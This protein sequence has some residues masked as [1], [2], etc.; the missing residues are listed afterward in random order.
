MSLNSYQPGDLIINDM[1]LAGKKVSTGFISG[2]IYESIFMPCVVGEFN[3][4]DNDDALFGG[5]NLSGGEPLNIT[6]QTP[7]GNKITY[8]FLIHKPQNLQPS[9]Q[10]KS[11]TMTLVCTSE[12]AFYAAGGVDTYGYIQK[13]YKGKTISSNVQD[14]LKSYLKTGKRINVEESK[15][16]QD[17]IANNEK[18]WEFID[19]IRRRAVSSKNQ[20]SSY[21]F[22]ENQDGFNFVTLESLFKGSSV[23]SFVQDATVGSDM[24]KL[25]DNN[26]FGYELPQIFSAMDRIDKGT[27][28]SRFSY[29]NFETN[30]YIQKSVDFPDKD[31]KSGGSGSWNTRAFTSKFGKY[32]GRKSNI[33]YD[34]RLPITNIPESTPNQLAYTGNMMQNFIKL[35]VP[36]DTKLKAGDLIEAKIQQ[37]NSLTANPKQDTDIS[38]NMV[39]ASLR[40]MINPEGQR[41]RYSCVLECLKGRPK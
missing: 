8:K 9:A 30:E 11:R 41:P 19:R 40:H 16:I 13:S 14:V 37:Q 5:L 18:A 1:T 12:E 34:N 36:G 31:D 3:M 23:K 28:K 38:G 10:Y 4:R 39:I 27:M 21:V 24:T 20:S 33:P 15:G 17:I 26:I 7:G 2:S 32:P 25:T 6:F 35:R 29:F 22:F